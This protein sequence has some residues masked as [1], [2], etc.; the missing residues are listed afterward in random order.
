[1]ATTSAVTPSMAL[2][3]APATGRGGDVM[4]VA[5]RRRR[6][7]RGSDVLEFSARTGAQ[8]VC[9]NVALRELE[10]QRTREV[11]VAPDPFVLARREELDDAAA[12]RR[13]ERQLR[14]RPRHARAVDADLRERP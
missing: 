9:G 13:P 10:A 1:M 11:P 6:D 3:P 7:A 12:R 2:A 14:R 4:R 8:L 5:A